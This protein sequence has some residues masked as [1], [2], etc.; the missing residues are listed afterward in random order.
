MS[1]SDIF[2]RAEKTRPTDN[3]EHGTKCELR[4]QKI[5]T[6]YNYNSYREWE[7]GLRLDNL[8]K[9]VPNLMRCRCGVVIVTAIKLIIIK[10][11]EQKFKI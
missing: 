1:R 4:V 2:E 7:N 9:W 5:D 10:S 8:V 6:S 3:L 11:L